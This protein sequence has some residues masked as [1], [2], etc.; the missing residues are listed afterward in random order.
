[1]NITFF[2]NQLNCKQTENEISNVDAANVTV[3]IVDVVVWAQY[4][5]ASHRVC[6]SISLISLG[7]AFNGAIWILF[8][9]S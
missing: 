5:S 2:S 9:F 8:V 1:M 7:I 3:I 6:F 4:A